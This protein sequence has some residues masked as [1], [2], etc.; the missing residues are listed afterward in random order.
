MI[1][2]VVVS[3]SPALAQAAVELACAMVPPARRPA[4][5]IAAGVQGGLGTDAVAILEA[6]TQVDG[7][8]GVLVLMDLGSALM[9]SEMAVEMLDPAVATRVRLSDAPLVEGLVGALVTAAS[10]GTLSTVAQQAETALEAKR[11]HFAP[12]D[13][14]PAAPIDLPDHDLVWRTVVHCNHG[15]HARPA[16]ALA[17]VLGSFDVESTVVSPRT[18]QQASG[19]SIIEIQ[20]LAVRRG[21]RVDVLLEGADVEQA[22]AALDLLAQRNFDEAPT[23]PGEPAP[24]RTEELAPEAP[25]GRWT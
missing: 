16:A 9:A 23:L 5:A 4:L 12:G 24:D 15:L 10:S 18:G 3:H 13:S 19:D 7:P 2:I 21:D 11:R 22:A 6:I 8:D 25:A 17:L 1:G 20:S 14:R